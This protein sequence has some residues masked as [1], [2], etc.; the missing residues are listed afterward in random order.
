MI[1]TKAKHIPTNHVHDI[2]DELYTPQAG[3]NGNCH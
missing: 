1:A 3:D 2:T